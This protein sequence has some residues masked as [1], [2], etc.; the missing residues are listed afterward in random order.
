MAPPLIQAPAGFVPEFAVSF[1]P[2]SGESRPVDVASPLPVQP[3]F[4]PARSAALAGDAAASGAIGPFTPDPGRPI[5]VTLAGTWSG[6]VSVLRSTDG[7]ATRRP[8]TLAGGAWGIFTANAQEAVGEETVAG[9]T[10]WLDFQR[11]SG[12][13][14]YEVAQ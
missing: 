9:A 3:G 4:A 13:L 1:G 10:W 2:R 7:G 11:T 12:I 8:L 14:A 5:W 6:T